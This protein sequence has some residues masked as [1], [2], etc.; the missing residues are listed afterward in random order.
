MTELY[1]FSVVP[2]RQGLNVLSAVLHKAA[3]HARE[4]KIDP[5]T[6]LTARLYPDMLPFTKQV[7]IA[8]DHAKQ[9]VARL[10]GIEAPRHEDAEQSFEELQ[11][12]IASTLSFIGQHDRGAF[13]GSGGRM[14]ELKLMGEIRLLTAVGYLTWFSLPNMYFHL[15][16]AYDILRHNGVPLGKRDFLGPMPGAGAR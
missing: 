10:L 4:H 7:Q 12:R 8:C 5:R 3:E 14:I 11:D 6:L 16:T 15:T 13:A 1:D 9:G 2:Y